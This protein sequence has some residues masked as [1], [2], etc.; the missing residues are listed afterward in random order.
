[1]KIGKKSISIEELYEI[2]QKPNMRV[3][4]TPIGAHPGETQTVIGRAVPWKHVK[5]SAFLSYV[6]P[7]GKKIADNLKKAIAVADKYRG[8]KGLAILHY[9]NGD[10]KVVPARAAAMAVGQHP[11]YYYVETVSGTSKRP[12]RKIP[13]RTRLIPAV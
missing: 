7:H 11:D 1:M 6:S 2:S 8:V 13:A 12:W 4:E 10:V 3:F 9:A 5:G